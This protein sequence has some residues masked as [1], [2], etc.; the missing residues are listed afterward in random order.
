MAVNDVGAAARSAS[1]LIAARLDRLPVARWHWR[2]TLLVGLAAFFDLYEV[3]MSGVL[4]GVLGEEWH[5]GKYVKATLIAAPF[6]G[7]IFGAIFLGIASDR[8][9]RRRMFMINLGT[10]SVLSVLAAFSPNIGVLIAIR[11]LCGVFMGAELILIDTY[12]SEYMPK[13]RRGRMIA[14]AYTIG[15]F[16]T[17]VVALLGGVLVARSHF[18]WEGWRWLLLCGG[19]GAMA[20]FIVRRGLPESA[21]WLAE[22]GRV[23]EADRIVTDIE[24]VVEAERGPLPAPEPPAPVTVWRVSLA[25]MF[26]PPYRR[27]TV[28]LWVFQ[29]LQTVGQY[30]FSSLVPIVL[31]DK[32][33]DIVDS[34]GYTAMTFIGAPVGAAIAI[35][36]VERYERKHLII[37]SGLITAGAG[38]LFGTATSPVLI[39]A[40]GLVITMS[41]NVLSGAYHIYHTELFPTQVRSSAIG[42]AYA[43]SRLSAAA[44]PFAGVALLDAF[45]SIGVFIGSA[46]LLVLMCVNVGVLGPRS[47][48]RSL[49]AITGETAEAGTGEPASSAVRA[50]ATNA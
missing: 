9:G 44:L 7:M 43:L 22:R 1:A 3:F 46:T 11:L 12:L 14:V 38:L 6:L 47:N 32:G 34:L 23:E 31:L 50:D 45:G 40:T 26:R 36:L 2:R 10:Y 49:E 30:G 17:P 42:M 29:L 19:L 48:G 8:Y 33:Y 4:G 35:P 20:V 37:A 28:M 18:L 5:L 41:N 15:F 24:R 16:G 39:V 13:L 27:R 21:R 25:D